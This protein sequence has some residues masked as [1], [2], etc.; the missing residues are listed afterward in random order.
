MRFDW[1][2]ATVRNEADSVIPVFQK[3]GDSS[4]RIDN[5]AKSKHW[6][7]GI[8]IK[9]Q[10]ITVAKAFW[11]GQNKVPHAIASGENTMKLVDLLR[12]EFPQHFVTRF[13]SCE[14][15]NETYDKLRK[16][17]IKIAR[18]HG[19]AFPEHKDELNDE[20][21]R[22]QYMGA[23]SSSIRFR[24]YE[25]GKQQ[26]SEMCSKAFGT[27][28][29][30]PD[31]LTFIHADTGEVLQGAI[32]TRAEIQVRPKGDEARMK[33]STATPL[34][35][36]GFTQWSHNLAFEL[37]KQEFE[38]VHVRQHKLTEDEIA[39]SWAL[40]QYGR[41]MQRTAHKLGGWEQ[42]GLMTGNTI[43]RMFK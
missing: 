14:D 8:A 22:T 35:A 36:W 40:K 34:E 30:M 11:G 5:E 27:L 3:L 9:A 39:L 7:N 37:F 4:E 33:A 42:F 32:W 25:K 19:V 10:G 15:F 1:Y 12:N 41:V 26:W 18:H 21:G 28:Y 13:D 24:L 31:E 29:A 2:Q 23:P 43:E 38:R 16:P 20:A 17:C 6:A